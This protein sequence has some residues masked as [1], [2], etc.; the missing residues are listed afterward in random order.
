VRARENRVLGRISE[1]KKEK[2]TE[3]RRKLHNEFSSSDVS[4]IKSRKMRW[5]GQR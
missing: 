2:A 4:V 1:P 3:S 5:G